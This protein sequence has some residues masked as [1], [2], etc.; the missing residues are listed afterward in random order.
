[1]R[2]S[3]SSSCSNFVSYEI[4]DVSIDDQF[5]FTTYSVDAAAPLY[6]ILRACEKFHRS[7]NSNAN[8]SACSRKQVCRIV[9]ESYFYSVIRVIRTTY[10][11]GGGETICPPP[12]MAVRRCQKSRRIYTSVHGRVLSPHISGGR[13]W[14][15]CRQPVCL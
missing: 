6:R 7:V 3:S 13:R 8:V 10:R 5:T 9:N 11:H 15:S 14:L 12:P 2:S 1:M 4:N